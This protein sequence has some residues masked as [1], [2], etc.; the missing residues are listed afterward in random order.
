MIPAALERQITSE[1]AP[2]IR[3]KVIA[4]AANGPV[5]A[6]AEQILKAKGVLIIPDLYLNVG[7]VTVS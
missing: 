2:R 5:T 3:A 4:E 1:N 6:E 7:G